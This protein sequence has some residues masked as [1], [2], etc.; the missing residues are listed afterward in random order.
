LPKPNPDSPVRFRDWVEI[1]QQH[2]EPRR[3]GERTR[4]RIRL[5]AAELLNEVGYR[6]M[7]VSDV[8]ERAG[9]TT[10]AL[11]MY[12]QN[13]LALT[14]DL[15]KEFVVE[16]MA[17]TTSSGRGRSVY[18]AMYDATLRW[19]E[20]ARANAGLMRC[21]LQISDEVPEFAEVFANA[22]RR[23]YERISS[24]LI[25]RFPEAEPDKAALGLATYAFGGMIDEFTRRLFTAG[26]E[27]LA[28]LTQ[29]VAPT[30]E[31]LAGFLTGL[32]YRGLYGRSPP[33]GP[34]ILPHLSAATEGRA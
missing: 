7:K 10:P 5:A 20:S 34:P 17:R 31:A 13:K 30:D 23:W 18:E 25:A 22:N 21:L 29:E 6:D 14:E 12:F 16:F 3:K 26:D 19:I 1:R 27:Q 9:V 2:A 33:D 32:W 11:Y 28:A 24:S 4:D 15:L 8:C